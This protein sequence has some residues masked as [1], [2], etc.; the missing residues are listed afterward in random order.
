MESAGQNKALLLERHFEAIEKIILSRQDP[1]TGLL[2]ASTAVNAHGDY[3][4]AWVRDNVYS[5]LCVWGLSLAY[6]RFDPDHE[7]THYLSHSVI[8]LMRGLLGAMMRQSD[9]VERF[10]YSL[11]PFDSLHAKY[12][13]KTGLSVVGD[14]EW[15]HLQ[16]DATSLFLLM[17][18]QMSVSGLH[19][20][21]TYDEV[22]FIQNLVHYIGKTYCTADYGIWERGNKINHG[23]P[24]INCSS[25]GM[26]KA[27]L[28]A[29]DGLKLFG[30]ETGQR[31]RIHVVLND[32]SSS[33]HTLRGLLPKESNSKET[34]A[35]LLSIIGFPAYAVEDEELVERT[36]EKILKKLCGNYGCKR[37]LLDGHQSV[38]ED[39]S[40]LHY[41][42]SELREFQHIESEWPLFFTY[43]LL[44]SLM[45][46]KAEES[47]HWFAKLEPL[48]VDSE[49]LKLL[50][51]LY[52]IPEKNIP[53][54]KRYPGSQIRLPNEN[55]PLVWAQSLYMLSQ[56]IDEKL[57]LPEDIDPLNRRV[58][59][60]GNR[61]STVAI[62]VIAENDAVKEQLARNGIDCESIE[63]LKP[64]AVLHAEKLTE[65]YTLI[66]K[67]TKL[68]LSGRP[69]AVMRT[70]S[71]TRLHQ[72]GSQTVLFLPYYASQKGF[73]FGYDN[74]L[75]VDHFRSSVK[76]LAKEWGKEKLPILPFLVREDML[77]DQND[78]NVIALLH[79]VQNGRIETFHVKTGPLH[80][81]L[82]DLEI[83]S[84]DTVHHAMIFP[85]SAD[86]YLLRR[87]QIQGFSESN[88]SLNS[89]DFH[90]LE[91][92]DE[93]TLINTAFGHPNVYYQVHALS[94]LWSQTDSEIPLEYGGDTSSLRLLA[95]RLYEN[96]VCRHDWYA[97]RRLAEILGMSHERI[98]EAVSEII[99]RQK[100][101]AVGRAYTEK[102]VL[103]H[104]VDRLTILKRIDEFCGN[105]S[106][107]KILTQ[108]IILH[109]G[110]LIRNEPELFTEMLTL[111]TWYLVQLIVAQIVKEREISMGNAYEELLKRSPHELYDRLH[112]ILE[113]Y[114][115]EV[116]T[117]Q[118]QEILHPSSDVRGLNPGIWENGIQ[119]TEIDDWRA[120]REKMGLLGHLSAT[121]HKRLW[122]LLQ[123][124]EG[125]VIGDKYS[126]QSRIG[127]ELTLESTAGEREFALRVDTLIQSIPAP[128]YRQLNIEAIESMIRLFT[129]N[130][131]LRIEDDLV[132]D[133]LIGH[134]VRIAWQQD[135]PNDNYDESKSLAW[136][137]FYKR[138]PKETD[139]AFVEAFIYLISDEEYL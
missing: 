59:E 2:P 53:E 3:T 52:Y 84:I 47:R 90:I 70:L 32:I 137:T 65:L 14:D 41:E 114:K 64:I 100:R 66:G 99:I 121:F 4:D 61:D 89:Y 83:E 129:Q 127:T 29:M 18:A 82:G 116:A 92:M 77:S 46:G 26:A 48:F 23:K 17:C 91:A 57:L 139:M 120:W 12:G 63:D 101:L 67:N 33:R 13:T 72:I 118:N 7:R 39:T 43:L 44:D 119:G 37:F 30:N 51:E 123:R 38:I 25:V 9:K 24:E 31:S 35:A 117:L 56:M 102:A 131:Q 69:D 122:H 74:R 79:E 6:R 107:E 133:V 97:V 28:E 130:P 138:S 45:R 76:F 105:N 21:Y 94:R 75:L 19:I 62:V 68:G 136:E 85:D 20:V 111:R 115:K 49:G 11:E 128:D 113:T 87:N 80:T 8:K 78:R 55:I 98:E 34:D 10:K 60:K 50:P 109:L 36:R 126:I 40:R 104:N 96:A 15:G 108:E 16:L 22:D 58:Y 135:S 88:V 71:T 27:A 110:Y 54:E 93:S 124:C 81:L 5:I 112:R 103:S 42:P 95:E 125:L 86:S 73:Y 134:A 132:L 1:V 106:A